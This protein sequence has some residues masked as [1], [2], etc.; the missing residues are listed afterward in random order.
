MLRRGPAGY[1]V[2]RPGLSSILTPPP[3]KTDGR[4]RYYT[5]AL[6]NRPDPE[7][8]PYVLWTDTLPNG[9]S[10]KVLIWPQKHQASAILHINEQMHSAYICASRELAVQKGREL[11][12]QVRAGE[13][14]S[15]DRP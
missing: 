10:A 11:R 2:L 4:R 9:E 13:V 6:T 3:G 7:F 12:K 1:S 8:R 5:P 14:T 15:P